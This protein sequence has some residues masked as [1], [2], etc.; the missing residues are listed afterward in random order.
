MQLDRSFGITKWS[1]G[2]EAHRN[3]IPSE[4]FVTGVPT[5]YRCYR[6]LGNLLIIIFPQM[7]RNSSIKV[8]GLE[9]TAVITPISQLLQN[10]LLVAYFG[11]SVLEWT[12][13]KMS[14][15]GYE[16]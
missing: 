1:V 13:L 11:K 10:R 14:N 9:M 6:N 4:T 3:Y 8:R 2:E 12:S 15:L 7:K 5:F 16:R